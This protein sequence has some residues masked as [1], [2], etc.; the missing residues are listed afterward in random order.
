[1]LFDAC[2]ERVCPEIRNAIACE[3]VLVFS[4]H[5]NNKIWK[6]LTKYENT[7]GSDEVTSKCPLKTDTQLS[8]SCDQF[9][10]QCDNGQCISIDDLCDGKKGILM[11]QY[12][13]FG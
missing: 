5:F 4:I 8:G 10:F 13:Y 11:A 3:I 9:S 6:L 2:T 1:M 12:E 7:D